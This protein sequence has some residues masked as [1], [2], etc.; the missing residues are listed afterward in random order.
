MSSYDFE[1]FSFML[2]DYVPEI[3]NLDYNVFKY[4]VV[5]SYNLLRCNEIL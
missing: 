4:D 2:K 3:V 1:L 5:G